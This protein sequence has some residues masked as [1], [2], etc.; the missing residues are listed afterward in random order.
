M[1][2]VVALLCIAVFVDDSVFALGGGGGGGL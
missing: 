1:V 2:G